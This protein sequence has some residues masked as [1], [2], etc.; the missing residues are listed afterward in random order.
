MEHH[1]QTQLLGRLVQ[2]VHHG[3][4]GVE[5]IIGGVQLHT[6]EALR[7]QLPQLAGHIFFLQRIKG[8]E[9]Q[10]LGVSLAEVRHHPVVRH[11]G[12]GGGVLRQDHGVVHALLRQ[13]GAEVIRRGV[14]L[15]H[16]LIR[17]L[18]GIQGDEPIPC[19][20][21]QHLVPGQMDVHINE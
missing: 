13:H 7:R 3:G 5:E 14:G 12:D 21:G 6:P 9:G 10:Q 20:G 16:R 8:A 15:A 19:A 18:G 2:W 17:G 4:V 11:T 1:R